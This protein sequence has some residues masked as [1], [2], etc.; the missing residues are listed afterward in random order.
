MV[1]KTEV[2]TGVE[3]RSGEGGGGLLETRNLMLQRDAA[4]GLQQE[5]SLISIC[6]LIFLFFDLLTT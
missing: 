4:R 6:W 2:G 3:K 1:N 5:S